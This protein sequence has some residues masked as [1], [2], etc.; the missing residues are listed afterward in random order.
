M[1]IQTHLVFPL[2]LCPHGAELRLCAQRRGDVVHNVNVNVVEN[3]AVAV[4]GRAR[5]IVHNV[6]KDDASLG[7]RHLLSSEEKKKGQTRLI[8]LHF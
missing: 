7:R 5:H 4:R 1:Q 8:C 6:A 3:H 2:K